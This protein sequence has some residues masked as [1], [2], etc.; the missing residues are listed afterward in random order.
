MRLLKLPGL[1]HY[2]RRF[3][4]DKGCFLM[5][6]AFVNSGDRNTSALSFEDNCFDIKNDGCSV[7]WQN[8]N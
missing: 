6:F 2:Y 5:D 8:L 7:G 3:N 4:E 1:E